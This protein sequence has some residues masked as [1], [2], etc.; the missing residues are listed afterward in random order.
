M[1]IIDKY[2]YKVLADYELKNQLFCVSIFTFYILTVV[3]KKNYKTV[4]YILVFISARFLNTNTVLHFYTDFEVLDALIATFR[5]YVQASP[6]DLS[7]LS[8]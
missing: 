1:K 7:F 6:T 2:P 5:Y 4:T 3:L 8:C